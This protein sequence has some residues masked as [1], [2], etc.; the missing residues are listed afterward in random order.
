M[1]VP[2]R[3]LRTGEAEGAAA[4]TEGQGVASQIGSGETTRIRLN[5]FYRH[6]PMTKYNRT[7]SF[8]RIALV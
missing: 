3:S 5:A 7:R 1:P 4:P 6:D 8:V 2:V